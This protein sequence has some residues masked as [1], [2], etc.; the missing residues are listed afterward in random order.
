MKRLLFCAALIAW[1]GLVSA[2]VVYKW[3]DG[4]GKVHYGDRP[5]DGVHAEV[6][7]MVGTRDR[8]TPNPPAASASDS[9]PAAPAQ[10]TPPKKISDEEAAANQQKLCADAQ[11]RYKKLIDGRHLYKVGDDGQRQYMTSEQIDTERASAK[12]EVDTVCNSST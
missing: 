12:Q 2:G 8:N 6:V 7:E 11:D 3:V 5:P 9:K 10:G 1:S 4:D